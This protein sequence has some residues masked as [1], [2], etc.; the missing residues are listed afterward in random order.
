MKYVKT[1]LKSRKA[2]FFTNEHHIGA[3]QDGH[4]LCKNTFLN[5]TEYKYCVVYTVP[6]Y[7]YVIVC[8]HCKFLGALKILNK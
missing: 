3:C 1:N 4:I 5:Q 7:M 8:N 2:Y 6:V